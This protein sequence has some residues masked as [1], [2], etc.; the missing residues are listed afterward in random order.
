MKFSRLSLD[1]QLSWLIFV[2]VS[3]LIIIISTAQIG[4]ASLS[5]VSTKAFLNLDGTRLV[6][7][8]TL[9]IIL[10]ILVAGLI[11]VLAL[12]HRSASSTRLMLPRVRPPVKLVPSQ[13]L[14][15]QPVKQVQQARPVQQRSRS[16]EEAFKELASK[17]IFSPQ[18]RS[19]MERE[20]VGSTFREI[21]GDRPDE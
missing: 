13:A 11:T 14:P 16:Q 12:Q 8:V 9:A 2:T 1:A 17:S 10:V 3:A 20:P 4:N 7:V 15:V 19:Q 5:P 18:M 6:L 21:R